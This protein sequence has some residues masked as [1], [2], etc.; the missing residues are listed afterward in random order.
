MFRN[1]TSVTA[2]DEISSIIG[3][4]FG[5]NPVE[6]N[7]NCGARPI[8]PKVR[9]NHRCI[10]DQACKTLTGLKAKGW[11]KIIIPVDQKLNRETWP[12]PTRPTLRIIT[13]DP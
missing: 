3:K 9:Q 13:I 4:L 1:R 12:F 8:F 2:S 7:K 11:T 10:L 5:G 6:L